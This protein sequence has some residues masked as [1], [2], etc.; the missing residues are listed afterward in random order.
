MQEIQRL[1]KFDNILD[2]I[3]D[4]AA[5]DCL[6]RVQSLVREAGSRRPS[7]DST[8]KI[9]MLLSACLTEPVCVWMRN[10]SLSGLVA[11]T[12][13]LIN[14]RSNADLPN[15]QNVTESS[16]AVEIPLLCEGALA[17]G[18]ISGGSDRITKSLANL[19]LLIPEHH[20]RYV[21]EMYRETPDIQNERTTPLQF[22]Q[23]WFGVEDP[24]LSNLFKK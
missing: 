4:K 20:N 10:E 16:A 12:Q 13:A 2:T 8:V 6:D 7:Y 5:D 11:V 9:L 18:S 3:N 24:T 17:A 14:V 22:D 21:T 15:L 1:A 19:L 23:K